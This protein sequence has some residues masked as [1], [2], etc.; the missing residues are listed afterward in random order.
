MPLPVPTY[1]TDRT[2]DENYERGPT[3]AGPMPALVP[4]RRP[5]EFLGFRLNSPLGVP[6][7]PLLNSAYVGLYARLGWDVPVYKTVRSV[8]RS[9]H[10]A[11]NC[12]FIAPDVLNE[13]DA[14]SVRAVEPAPQT[15]AG[16]AITN[17]FGMPSKA[18]DEW[19]TDVRAAQDKMGEGQLLIVSIVGTPGAGG[20][21]LAGDFAHTA[22][23]A[24]EAGARV[25]EANFSCPN[26]VSGEGSL[27]S[28]PDFSA[29][30]TGRIRKE[31]GDTP[32]LI[33]IGALPEARLR[34]VVQA[35][36]ANIDGIAA[37][38]TVPLRIVDK[39]GGQALPGDGRLQS[40][41]C[42]AAIRNVAAEMTARLVRIRR[43]L[44]ARFAVISVGGVMTESDIDGRVALGADLV[45][46]A[47]AAMWDPL[48]ASRWRASV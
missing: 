10:P 24:K 7:G 1:D 36:L 9:C 11:P 3:F 21:D 23:L 41:V 44:G 13:E 15:V 35:N 26:V 18:P 5:Q 45:M 17:S 28:D 19:M 46:S 16:L 6:A 33:K 47:T 37:I 27:Y 2:Y 29:A 43:D 39:A 42:G 14:L 48:L 38:N 4:P 34:S 25:I 40:G 22:A 20:R 12:L 30:V 31:I 32:L 8:A